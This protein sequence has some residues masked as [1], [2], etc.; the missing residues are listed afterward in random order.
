MDELV[1]GYG[2]FIDW[3]DEV[4]LSTEVTIDPYDDE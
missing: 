1:N 2:G 3:D 4:C